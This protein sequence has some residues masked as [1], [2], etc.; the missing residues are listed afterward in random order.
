[1]TGKGLPEV[2]VAG[3]MRLIAIRTMRGFGQ[4]ERDFGSLRGEK[5]PLA[6]A[7]CWI[8]LLKNAALIDFDLKADPLEVRLRPQP[9]H[10]NIIVLFSRW[11]K[12]C[13]DLLAG[14]T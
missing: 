12:P 11:P 14:W 8:K 1:V 13:F 9:H 2:W 3:A 6:T 4:R 5:Y 7:F 10:R